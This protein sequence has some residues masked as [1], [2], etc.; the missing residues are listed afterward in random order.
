MIDKAMMDQH[1]QMAYQKEL[2]MRQKKRKI[3]PEMLSRYITAYI[4]MKGT[5]VIVSSDMENSFYLQCSQL[6]TNL[7]DD[8]LSDKERDCL[9]QC[10]RKIHKF[11]AIAKAQFK[12]TEDEIK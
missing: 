2:A 7:D 8:L 3:D 6:C 1:Q 5:I 9:G 12:D 10:N 11:L 4:M